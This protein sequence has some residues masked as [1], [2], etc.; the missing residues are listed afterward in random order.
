M[1]KVVLYDM[2]L[3]QL[4]RSLVRDHSIIKLR[5]KIN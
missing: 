2:L 3:L 4:L 1:L 5:Y